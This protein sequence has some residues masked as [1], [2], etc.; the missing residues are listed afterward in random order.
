MGLRFVILSIP[1][2]VTSAKGAAESRL[3]CVEI[4]SVSTDPDTWQVFSKSQ[5]PLLQ[6]TQEMRR[7]IKSVTQWAPKMC[8]G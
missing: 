1:E 5:T 6:K 4:N 2:V 7:K 8:D 3:Q